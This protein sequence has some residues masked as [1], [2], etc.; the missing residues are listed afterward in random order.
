MFLDFFQDFLDFLDFLDFCL[1]VC[2]ST[3]KNEEGR[4][5]KKDEIDS[6]SP[7][8]SIEDTP[9]INF[10]QVSSKSD[11]RKPSYEQNTTLEGLC[12][13]WPNP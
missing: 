8:E 9:T 11:F 3:K 2:L 10:H 7:R 6:R 4:K 12:Y 1:S 13:M 5:R